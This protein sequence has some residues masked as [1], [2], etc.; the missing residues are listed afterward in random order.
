MPTEGGKAIPDNGATLSISLLHRHRPRLEA[1][2]RSSQ[3]G[4]TNG[5]EEVG[6]EKSKLEQPS[7]T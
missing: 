4:S 2:A 5:Y 7:V 6:T 3:G 1:F